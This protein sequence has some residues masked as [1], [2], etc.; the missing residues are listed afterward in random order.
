VK[1][2]D[3][4][5][6]RARRDASGEN[7]LAELK[8]SMSGTRHSK[9]LDG[10]ATS[11]QRLRLGNLGVSFQRLIP[12]G[13]RIGLQVTGALGVDRGRVLKTLRKLG[14]RRAGRRTN[15]C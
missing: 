1:D 6:R 13:E 12:R 4:S 2:R 7:N 5:F 9:E 10:P 8:C 3:F 14:H 15:G 11:A